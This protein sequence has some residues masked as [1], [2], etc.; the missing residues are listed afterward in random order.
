M[1]FDKELEAYIKTLTQDPTQELSQYCFMDPFSGI[2]QNFNM[3]HPERR[4]N[5][6]FFT[7]TSQEKNSDFRERYKELTS[8]RQG[9][10]AYDI[11]G[12]E[13]PSHSPWFVDREEYKTYVKEH[14]IYP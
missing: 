13:L 1:P 11:H 10:T 3:L 4:S 9:E 6:R 14:P 8:L 12:R 5:E 2:R 7:N